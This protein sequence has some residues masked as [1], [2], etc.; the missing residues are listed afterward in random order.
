M[1]AMPGLAHSQRSLLH[2]VHSPRHKLTTMQTTP[3]MIMKKKM[4]MM[5]RRRRGELA[6]VELEEET[7]EG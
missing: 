2:Q 3:R 5:M 4:M 6:E 7:I 1:V